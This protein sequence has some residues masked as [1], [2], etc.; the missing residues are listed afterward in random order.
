MNSD[1][2]VLKRPEVKR[3]R[4]CQHCDRSNKEMADEGFA[5]CNLRPKWQYQAPTY[6]CNK[7]KA[8]A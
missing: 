1:G 4:N 2:G 7:W 3:C 6:T 5:R 8:K